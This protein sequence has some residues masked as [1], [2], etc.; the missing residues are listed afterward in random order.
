MT[1]LISYLDHNYQL[2]TQ[3]SRFQ[4]DEKSNNQFQYTSI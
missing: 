1:I 3:R 2:T 4:K